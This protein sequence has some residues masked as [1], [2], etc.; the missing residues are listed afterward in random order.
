MEGSAGDTDGDFWLE[1]G[2]S[3]PSTSQE[4]TLKKLVNILLDHADRDAAI[5]AAVTAVMSLQQVNA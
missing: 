2:V 1:D 5:A 3:T 4:G